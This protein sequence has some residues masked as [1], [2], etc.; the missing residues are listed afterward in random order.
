[1]RNIN[2]FLWV[3]FFYKF[4]IVQQNSVVQSEFGSCLTKECWQKTLT[5]P[6]YEIRIDYCTTRF[7]CGRA[8]NIIRWY[9]I[10]HCLMW[11][12]WCWIGVW[13]GVADFIWICI[14][15]NRQRLNNVNLCLLLLFL[16]TISSNKIRI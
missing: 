2:S 5:V 9:I 16:K 11:C 12:H 3:C 10:A 8:V 1:M 13:T 4:L 14:S 6:S 7:I 15:V